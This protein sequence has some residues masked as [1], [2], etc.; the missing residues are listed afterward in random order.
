[1]SSDL[2]RMAIN[3]TSRMVGVSHCI[4]LSQVHSGE[5]AEKYGSSHPDGVVSSFLEYLMTSASSSALFV[6]FSLL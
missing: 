5:S 4:H 6:S 2:C 1:M 3:I